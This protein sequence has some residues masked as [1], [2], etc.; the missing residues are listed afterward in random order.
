MIATPCGCSAMSPKPCGLSRLVLHAVRV[1]LL[2]AWLGLS[3][4]K[5]V[6]FL[7]E[8]TSL[9]SRLDRGFRPPFVSVQ[10]GSPLS[11]PV[12]RIVAGGSERE[13]DELFANRTL[14]D[15]IEAHGLALAEFAGVTNLTDEQREERRVEASLDADEGTWR[16]IVTGS[17]AA[18]ATLTPSSA[19]FF[20]RLP[21]DAKFAAE[22]SHDAAALYCYWVI[23][24]SEPDFW[25]FDTSLHVL[26]PI[27]NVSFHRD[28][29]VVVNREVKRNLWRDPCEADPLYDISAC[30]R[31]CFFS[32]INC[33]LDGTRVDIKPRCM[34]SDFR[35]Y[36][37]MFYR[38]FNHNSA[39]SDPDSTVARCRCPQ[40]CVRDRI[41]YT[42]L[43]D[44][45]RSSN[46]SFRVSIRLSRVRRTMVMV[47][48]YGLEDL[49]ADVGGYLGLLLGVSLLSLLGDGHQLASQLARRV[50]PR[51][52]PPETAQDGDKRH[53][54][55]AEGRP[56]SIDGA[57]AVSSL[58]H[59]F[60]ANSN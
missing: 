5:T 16:R 6:H 53:P 35:A 56:W 26:L 23:F 8:P 2:V 50:R 47:V 49:L 42:T 51:Q 28:V 18:S 32:W 55:N 25:R 33:S 43:S 45:T 19:Q 17:G 37:R 39:D 31:D 4:L 7:S 11:S 54:R 60:S 48:T 10:A 22:A 52:A 14:L 36:R 41:S 9:R 21:R 27:R 20:L 12:G 46:D 24:H 34:A 58:S 57:E 29:K 30:Q 44:V 1:A 40:P 59:S 15:F 38:F 13:R 3:A